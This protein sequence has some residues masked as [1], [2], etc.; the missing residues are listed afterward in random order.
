MST[1]LH[2]M[3]SL[4]RPA[5]LW[6]SDKTSGGVLAALVMLMLNACS[7]GEPEIYVERQVDR[8][9]QTIV[10]RIPAAQVPVQSAPPQYIVPRVQQSFAPAPDDSN[11]WAVRTGP[12]NYGQYRSQQWGPPEPRRP[13]YMQPS[14]GSQYR[15]LD[16]ES[17]AGTSRAPVAQQ[18]MQ[19]YWPLAPYDRLSG[20]SFGA[21]GYPY[22][23][24]YPGYYGDPGRVYAPGWPATGWPGYR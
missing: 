12:Q 19:G 13:Q 1:D 4:W 15:P 5:G 11:P 8:Q 17:K 3:A 21:S 6:K 18:P 20:S 7:D 2:Q 14:T 16:T 24:A 22:G 10:V 9:P 23:G